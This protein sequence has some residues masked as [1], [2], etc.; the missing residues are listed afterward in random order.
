MQQIVFEVEDGK[1]YCTHLETGNRI[2]L[3]E[4]EKMLLTILTGLL[5]ERL[6]ENALKNE[7]DELTA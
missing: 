4:N 5:A 2:E 7:I 1:V 6:Q 3:A